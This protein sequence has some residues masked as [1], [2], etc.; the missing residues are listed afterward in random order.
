MRIH[1]SHSTDAKNY[2][3]C[4]QN[5]FL[6]KII[7]ISAIVSCITYIVTTFIGFINYLELKYQNNMASYE[8][9]DVQPFEVTG[10]IYTKEGYKSSLYDNFDKDNKFYVFNNGNTPI[11]KMSINYSISNDAIDMINNYSKQGGVDF[12][13]SINRHRVDVSTN[14]SYYLDNISI[15]KSIVNDGDIYKMASRYVYQQVE[16]SFLLK[17]ES[18]HFPVPQ[19]LSLFINVVSHMSMYNNEFKINKIQNIPIN[20]SLF[21]IDHNDKYKEI[22]YECFVVRLDID[23]ENMT[24]RAVIVPSAVE[25]KQ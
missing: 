1:K 13:L 11:R 8:A 22:K 17:N 6:T 16:N 9:I 4:K 7:A 12:N 3:V 23:H 2:Y 21:Y 20:L 24:Y 25:L 15:E 5:L 10:K 18:A 19:N 14:Y